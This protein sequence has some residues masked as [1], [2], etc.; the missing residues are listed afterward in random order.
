[1]TIEFGTEYSTLYDV[2]YQDKDYAKESADLAKVL[3]SLGVVVGA[4]VLDVGC[5]TGRH[6]Q[7]LADMGYAVTAT[8]RSAPMLARALERCGERVA[9][10]S[11]EDYVA[12]HEQ[13]DATYSMFDVVSYQ[14][15][16]K[17]LLT[18]LQN[19]ARATKQGGYILGDAWHLPGV[20]SDPPEVREAQFVDPSGRKVVR[21]AQPTFDALSGT[22]TIE[23]E[24]TIGGQ[25]STPYTEVHELRSFT[26]L[27]MELA[28]AAV[29]LHVLRFSASPDMTAPLRATDWHFGFVAVKD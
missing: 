23:Y 13:F 2:F 1:M 28:L 6:A 11:S 27:E 12:T 19:M 26:T 15:T 5:G 20:L 25:E 9:L 24:F 3:S 18:F 16:P 8:D 4:N 14:T 21:R 29:G 22:A 7:V 17:D 10:L